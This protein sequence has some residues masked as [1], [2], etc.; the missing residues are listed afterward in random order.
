M[1]RKAKEKKGTKR[2]NGF[3]GRAAFNEAIE[4][5]MG[6]GIRKKAKH[7]KKSKHSVE[8]IKNKILEKHAYYQ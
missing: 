4:K 7:V 5:I 8:E 2:Q 1:L 6:K 3:R